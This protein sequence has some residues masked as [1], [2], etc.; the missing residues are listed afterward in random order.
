MYTN[1]YDIPGCRNTAREANIQYYPNFL[2]NYKSFKSFLLR[3]VN[4]NLPKTFYKFSDGEYKKPIYLN[5]KSY[6]FYHLLIEER[7]FRKLF[8]ENA[9]KYI[10]ESKE[11]VVQ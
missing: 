8:K 7:G 1:R 5:D 9:Q 11:Y 3:L 4:E 2:E 6:D 10:N